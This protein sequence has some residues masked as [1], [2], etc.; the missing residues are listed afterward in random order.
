MKY[1]V[2]TSSILDGWNRYWPPD[3]FPGFW[4]KVDEAIDDGRMVATE[5]V[6]GELKKKDDAVFKWAK[7]RKKMFVPIDDEIQEAVTN[8]LGRFPKL[9]DT[10][11]NRSSCDP[12]VI[13]L[14]QTRG[15][16]VLTGE[17]PTTSADRPHIPDVCVAFGVRWFGLVQLARDEGWV[18]AG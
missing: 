17:R 14:A 13:G 4:K 16:S 1:S 18:F 2:D 10:R 9:L 11:R 3:V 7:A 12:W 8:I 6:L 15:L 5:E